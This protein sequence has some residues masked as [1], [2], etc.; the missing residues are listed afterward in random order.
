MS[1]PNNIQVI[2]LDIEGTTTPVDFV[3]KVLFPYAAQNLEPFLARNEGKTEVQEDLELLAEEYQAEES[4]HLPPWEDSD[5]TASA[6]AYL[7]WLMAQDRKST[8][9]KSIQ[10]KIWEA[11]F[12]SGEIKGEVFADT[13]PA[14]KRWKQ[15]GYDLYIFSSGSVLAQKLL[16]ENSTHGDLSGYLSGHFDTNTGSKKQVDSYWRIA[17][18]IGCAP[19]QILFISDV[20][21]ELDAARGAGMH[22][23]Q[24]VRPGNPEGAGSCHPVIHDFNNL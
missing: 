21:A 6:L 14:L 24:S 9:L 15:E 7:Q 12:R 19:G 5:P 1:L 18:H 13:P 20:T 2:L 22:T 23:M 4:E 8:A 16:F 3:Y 17:G 11:G 10:G